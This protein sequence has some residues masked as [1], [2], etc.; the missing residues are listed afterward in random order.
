MRTELSA[1]Y[2]INF[3]ID[4]GVEEGGGESNE[5]QGSL[6][7]DGMNVLLSFCT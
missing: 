3:G 7:G 5:G 1:T 2:N 4:L 6:R